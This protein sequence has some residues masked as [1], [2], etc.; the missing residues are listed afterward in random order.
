MSKFR[1]NTVAICGGAF[2]DEGKGKLTDKFVSD[3]SR[4]Y[5]VVVYRD[6]G[7]ANAGHTIELDNGKRIAL[8]LLP[9]GVFSKNS[10]TII[11]KGMVIHPDDL[12]G[13][14]NGVE[15]MVN[16]EV[17]TK[18]LIDEM[19]ILSLDTHRA[20]ESILKTWEEG[21][22]GSTARGISP[23]YAD[24]L[25]RHPVRMRDL[26]NFNVEKFT[27][28]YRLYEALVK[29]MGG[30]LADIEVPSI[31]GPKKVG[32]LKEFLAKLQASKKK[33]D[34]YICDVTDFLKNAWADKKYAFV[35]EKA[36]AVGLDPR[37][38]VYP[39]VTSSDTTFGGILSSTEGVVDPQN[40]GIRVAV[41]KATYMSSVGTRKIPTFVPETL[42]NRIREDAH[43]YGATTKRPRDIAYLDLPAIKFFNNVN[44]ANYLALTHMD[45]V[46]PDTQVKVCIA[47]EV[48]GK[49][50][51]YRPDQEF[52]SKV[53]P[54]YKIFK[55]W[56]KEAISS[57]KTWKDIP[58]EAKVFLKFVAK[59]IGIP[60][61]I[62]TMG[63]KRS[64]S[65]TLK[66]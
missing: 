20:F 65:M 12:I 25:L 18:I 19:A 49:K 32:T 28:H 2:G 37:Y 48:D 23:A 1:K 3:F 13:E 26:R 50:T 6:N 45:I 33:L 5:K 9:S 11:G 61:L 47:Y 4:K 36:Q 52:I 34:P 35:F 63:P 21:G 29:G 27:R 39:D 56:N 62:I 22:K 30:V 10:T 57:A 42:A 64:Q 7:G 44:H 43:E 54:I 16:G 40:I 41:I 58:K 46:Y 15:A 24:V 66:V 31:N 60:I 38:G 59:E 55:T 14:I 53:K 8:H 51:D 17:P